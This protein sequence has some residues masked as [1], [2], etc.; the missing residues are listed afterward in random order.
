[1]SINSPNTE[2]TRQT[3][4]AL[5]AT[6]GDADQGM[7]RL[8]NLGVDP[9]NIGLLEP[10]D[11]PRHPNVR[12]SVGTFVGALA[13]AIAGGVLGAV[14]LG[15]S[16]F[17]PRLV[18]AVIGV[19]LGGYAGALFGSFFGGDAG[20]P[21]EPYFVRAIQD[22][23]IL[24]SADLPDRDGENHAVA[25]LYESSALEVNSLGTGRLD[26]QFRH[27]LEEVA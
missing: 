27:P 3:L 18:A 14:G 12:R 2:M 11:A 13:G 19:A 26:M 4:V 7:S 8:M 24:V 17:G 1:M 25:A 10:G 5:F 22:G 21:D 6:R 15:L 16:S 23:R 20:H 9:G